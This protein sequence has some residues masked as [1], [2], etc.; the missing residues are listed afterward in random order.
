MSVNEQN[1]KIWRIRR[2][3]IHEVAN[4]L[5]LHLGQFWAISKTIWTHTS[6]PPNSYPACW[7]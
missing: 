1:M 2:I 3:T 4:M 7:V 5:G 6:L